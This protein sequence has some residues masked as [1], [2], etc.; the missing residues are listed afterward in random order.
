MWLLVVVL[1]LTLSA[2]TH[3]DEYDNE[4]RM[5]DLELSK[6]KATEL[7]RSIRKMKRETIELLYRLA[8]PVAR[9]NSRVC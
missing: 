9:L 4:I 5:L 8:A 3:A 1:T 7:H 6:Q 2:L